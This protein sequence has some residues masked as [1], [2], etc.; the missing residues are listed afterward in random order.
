MDGSMVG[1]IGGSAGWTAALAGWQYYID[2]S[3]R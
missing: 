2:G 1:R 3:T